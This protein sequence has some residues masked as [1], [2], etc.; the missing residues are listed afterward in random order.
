[1]FKIKYL[2]RNIV[3]SIREISLR[4][5]IENYHKRSNKEWSVKKREDII[6]N[7]LILVTFFYY[8][9]KEN[10]RKA[11]LR[12]LIYIKVYCGSTHILIR[13]KVVLVYRF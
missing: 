1:M 10:E 5:I 6:I 7:F 13:E 11:I 8:F 2:T 4:I 3:F 9:D 12:F